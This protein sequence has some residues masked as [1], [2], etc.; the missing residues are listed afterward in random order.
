MPTF[1]ANRISANHNILFPD[2]IDVEDD[3]V[4]YYKGA[5]IGYQTTVIQRVSISSVRLVSNILFADIIIESSGGR[6]IEINGLT[7]SDAREVYNL[8]Q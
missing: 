1:I 6:R 2:R 8:L 7:K 3:R 4:V 5:L